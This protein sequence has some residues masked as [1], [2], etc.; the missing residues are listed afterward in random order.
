MT[1]PLLNDVVV[2]PA[3]ERLRLLHVLMPARK[4]WVIDVQERLALPRLVG[5][6]W[7][8][9]QCKPLGSGRKASGGP[10][11]S[12]AT[13]AML[14]VRDVAMARIEPLVSS[15]A[16]FEPSSR[17][18]LVAARAVEV[19]CSENTLLKDLR[20]YW[21][22]GQTL[23]ALLPRYDKCGA[24]QGEVSLAGRRRADGSAP[25]AL[26]AKDKDALKAACQKY[27]AKAYHTVTGAHQWMLEQH[28]TYKDGNGKKFIRPEQECPSVAQLY[29]WLRTRYPLEYRL[30]ARLGDKDFERDHRH[31]LGSIE[32]DCH[33]AG[34]LY[35]IDATIAD[36]YLV[37]AADRRLIVGK[38]T[39]YF[40][41]DRATRLIVGWYVGFESPCWMAAMQ[42]VLS[43]AEDKAE[44]CRRFGVAYDPADWPAHGIQ[45][46]QFLADQ[47][48]F[49]SRN[50]RRVSP[51]LRSTVSNVPGLR[52]DHKPLA[53]CTF[54]MIYQVIAMDLPAYDPPSNQQRR[55]G[56]AYFRDATL[57]L[58]EFT[59]LIV[60]AIVTH[61]RTMQP[62]MRLSLKQ[63]AHGVQPVPTQLWTHE[64]EER[65][66]ALARFDADTV[67]LELLPQETATA[68][69][70]GIE[71]RGARYT[72]KEGERAGWFVEARKK[73]FKVTVSLDLRLC[74]SIIAHDPFTRGRVYKAALVEGM[75]Q[76]EGM[77]FAELA[78][79]KK[80]IEA[81][82]AP[83]VQLKR[84]NRLEYHEHADAVREDA[85]ASYDE[86][87]GGRTISRKARRKD[88]A[89]AR[90][91]ERRKE[92]EATAG[93][94]AIAPAAVAA[95]SAPPAPPAAPAPVVTLVGASA[96]PSND[97]AFGERPLTLKERLAAQRKKLISNG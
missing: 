73:R 95:Q 30:R 68:T 58:H 72:F 87:T 66:G 25:Y 54:K 51:G 71:L 34:H 53:E 23:D 36:V 96:Q 27:L 10:T 52:P 17:A 31:K 81:L 8:A 63:V 80:A 38:P 45:P 62:D 85:Q 16:I 86:A 43:I 57:T 50:A 44:V 40:I 15:P 39:L 18:R 67:R 37:S 32:L 77:S 94:P 78:Q 28:Y 70:H 13:P 92:R 29:N 33:G 91:E 5:Y 47:G 76:Y 60:Q 4:A 11:S 3:D 42:A 88:V 69:E 64:V 7:L 2:T 19:M 82:T 21:Q 84:Q 26:Q 20:R 12:S 48:E 46:E 65:A 61:N 24:Q 49:A 14:R 56:K 97:E 9:A 75:K 22:G 41:T 83:S 90:T 55:R 74:D 35:E 59:S 93:M 79:H 1:A 89:V 6:D